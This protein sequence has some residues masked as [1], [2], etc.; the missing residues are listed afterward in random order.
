MFSTKFVPF[1][2]I[3][4]SIPQISAN[5]QIVFRLTTNADTL[6][7]VNL[8][9]ATYESTT[10]DRPSQAAP[11]VIMHGLFGSKSNWNSL[12]K[13][14]QQKCNPQRK[15]IA[16]DAR[17]HGDSPHSSEHTYAHLAADL[18]SLLNQLGVEKAAF[19]GHSMGGRAV[20]LFAL[21]Y[22]ELVDRLIVGDISPIRNSPN[23]DSMPSL[24][25]AMESVNLP[26]NVTMSQARS[27]VDEQL[28]KYMADKSLRAFLITNLVA[29]HNGSYTWRINIPALMK[30][31][32]NIARFPMV[33]DVHYDGPV[34]FVAGG[35]SDFVHNGMK[36]LPQLLAF[37]KK[38]DIPE[39]LSLSQ[40]R[41]VAAE[42]L[43]GFM[44]D[45]NA[46]MFLVTNLV[47]RSEGRKSDYPKI[48]KLFPNA[49]LTYI[50]GAGHWLHSEKPSEFLKITLDFLNRK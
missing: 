13:V 9:Y 5:T 36:K 30:N 11:L 6:Q 2:N 31:F 38:L 40:A 25:Q 33:N 14:Y 39:T 35:H 3:L 20:M 21:K 27:I 45:P 12:S 7:P 46:V 47:Q 28:T 18:K 48:Q 44:K 32:N 41:K 19:M 15:V 34:L 17:N 22:P 37:L 23:L 1:N 8:S 4:K 29:T 43:I 50:E 24:F 16:V 49:E 42:K 26:S 10:A